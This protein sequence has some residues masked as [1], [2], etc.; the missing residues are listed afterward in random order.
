MGAFKKG[1]KKLKKGFRF[2]RGGKVVKAK[3]TK[4]ATRKRTKRGRR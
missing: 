2:A 3:A 4:P 1:T